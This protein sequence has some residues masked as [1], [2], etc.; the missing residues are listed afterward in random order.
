VQWESRPTV[1]APTRHYYDGL[2]RHI[3]HFL[4]LPSQRNLEKRLEVFRKP[5]TRQAN[6]KPKTSNR[7]KIHYCPLSFCGSDPATKLRVK[8]SHPEVLEFI[9]VFGF[10]QAF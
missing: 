6:E 5:A 4:T 7:V 8:S 9:S 3:M 2:V 1:S 10:G